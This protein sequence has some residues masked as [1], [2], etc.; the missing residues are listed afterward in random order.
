MPEGGSS[1]S[2]TRQYS[3]GNP[4]PR[5]WSVDLWS[6]VTGQGEAESQLLSLGHFVLCDEMVLWWDDFVTRW[7]YCD[8]MMTV[9]QHNCLTRRSV[10][11][12]FVAGLVAAHVQLAAVMCS[13]FR[14]L[15][16]GVDTQVSSMFRNIAITHILLNTVSLP[17]IWM[18]DVNY[19]RASLQ[20]R[21][22]ISPSLNIVKFCWYLYLWTPP[23]RG[24]DKGEQL[25]SDDGTTNTKTRGK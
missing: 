21:V 6:H 24:C 16:S 13:E 7:L 22:R 5:P 20:S 17:E 9:W 2:F 10:S 4:T 12:E 15:V 3:W 8:M 18:L 1:L 23:C 25:G 14:P 11:E 19:W